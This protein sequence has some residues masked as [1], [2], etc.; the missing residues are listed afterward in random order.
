MRWYRSAQPGV[1]SPEAWLV[2]V[3]TRLCI[4][5]L[6][7]L[8]NERAQYSGPWLPE[9]VAA[10][11]PVEQRLEMSEDLTIAF[12]L[13][14]ERL[15]PEERAAL[16]LREA[17][18]YAYDEV[19]TAL[20]RSESA[21]RQ[22]VH[23]AKVAIHDERRAQRSSRTAHRRIIT[24]LL[25]AIEQGDERRL[26]DLVA[27]EA[28]WI[29]DGGGNV[30]GAATNE[31]RGADRVGRMLVGLARKSRDIFS[32]RLVELLGQPAIHWSIG[33]RLIGRELPGLSQDG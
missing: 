5:K 13:M 19:A 2:T 21:C 15:T 18:G 17:L 30:R 20:A 11:A 16:V 22:L 23:R 26:L 10:D 12:L 24:S 14:L 29:A 6:R 33:G 8:K 1:R 25:D 27:D 3:V 28:T 9:P 32:M 7:S 4:D 31:L